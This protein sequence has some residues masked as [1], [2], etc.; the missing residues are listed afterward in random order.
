MAFLWRLPI[1]LVSLSWPELVD[2]SFLLQAVTEIVTAT[3]MIGL[4]LF[5]CYVVITFECI[6]SDDTI[7]NIPTI[8]REWIYSL[9]HWTTCCS[10]MLLSFIIFIVCHH[11]QHRS[12]T[13]LF[14]FSCR[15]KTGISFEGTP[16]NCSDNLK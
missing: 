11:H 9:G 8:I 2:T 7:F 5:W 10:S 14:Y 16:W 1:V 3:T 15:Y 13:M 4:P 6:T 12:V